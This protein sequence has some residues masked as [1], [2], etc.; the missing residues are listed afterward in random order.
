MSK[1]FMSTI[2]ALATTGALISAPVFA[3]AT[4]SGMTPI[5]VAANTPASPDHSGGKAPRAEVPARAD[6]MTIKQAYDTLEKAGYK[7][8]RSI[9]SSRFGYIAYVA[10]TDNKRVRLLVHPTEGTVTIQERRKNHRHKDHK[11]DDPHPNN[12]SGTDTPLQNDSQQP[13]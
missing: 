6:W 2:A 11:K 9:S 1:F 10:D 3:Q 4:T 8:I 13:A 5:I 7:D 12:N